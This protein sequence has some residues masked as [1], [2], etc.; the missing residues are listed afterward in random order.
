MLDESTEK[1]EKAALMCI[2][3]DFYQHLDGIDNVAKGFYWYEKSLKLNSK[4]AMTLNNYAYFRSL[5]KDNLKY[6][7]R[8][9]KK[10]CSIEPENATYLDTLGYIY[11]LLGD[12]KTAKEVFIKCL[13]YGGRDEAVIVGHYADVLNALGEKTADYYYKLSQKLLQEGK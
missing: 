3:A 6:A 4:S 8:M 7:L 10:A 5:K 1:L 13:S 2:I 11:Y 12:Y 9:S